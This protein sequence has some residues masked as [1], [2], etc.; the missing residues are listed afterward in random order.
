MKDVWEQAIV[1]KIKEHRT[2]IVDALSRVDDTLTE[3]ALEKEQ[4]ATAY[5]Q[6]RRAVREMGDMLALVGRVRVR[7][8]D[9]T[10]FMRHLVGE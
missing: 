3:E 9:G 5:L 8:L 7:R 4:W 2:M 1:A 6:L 10:D